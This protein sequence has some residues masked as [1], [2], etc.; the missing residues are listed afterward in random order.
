MEIFQLKS[1]ITEDVKCAIERI[2]K[3]LES[4]LQQISGKIWII[5]GVDIHSCTGIHD[6]DILLIG[7]LKGDNRYD[8]NGFQ[9]IK[10]R[11]FCTVIEIKN[12]DASGIIKEGTHLKVRYGAEEKDVTKQNESQKESLKRFL[13]NVLG[14]SKLKIPY[15]TN[16]I[17]LDGIEK[18]DFSRSIGLDESNIL[19]S[20][21]TFTDILNALGRRTSLRNN[22][23]IDAFKSYDDLK[24]ESFAEIFIAKVRGADTISLRRINHLNWKNNIE[25]KLLYH[26]KNVSILAGHAGTGKTLML[27]KSAVEKSKRGAKILFLTYNTALLSDLKHTVSLLPAMFLNIEMKSMHSYLISH[28]YRHNLWKNESKIEC[29]FTLALKVFH[30]KIK[31]NKI[32]ETKYDAVYIDEAQDW[33][34]PL[35]DIIKELFSD[36]KIIIA[37][38]IDQFMNKEDKG[39]WVKKSFPTLKQCKRQ[40][41]NL[42]IFVRAFASKLGVGWNVLPNKE[43][44]GGKVIVLHK[45]EPS[46]HFKLLKKIEKDD[47]KE[48][49]LML[50]ASNSM[51][52]NGKFSLLEEYEKRGIKLYDGTNKNIREEIYDDKCAE[53]K[54]SRIYSYESCRGLESWITVCLRYDEL[55]DKDHPHDYKDIQY[56]TAR[57]YMKALW[58]LIPL[59]RAID[60]LVLVVKKQCSLD[61]MLKELAQEYPDIVTYKQ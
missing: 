17:W 32:R 41:R 29:D 56:E 47:C 15:I 4:A 13:T 2:C 34:N 36:K 42:T 10:L 53:R 60:T 49:D 37:D 11:S 51:M 12:H 8:L 21:S 22:G 46:N 33:A 9:N 1:H 58:S 44:P 3:I 23:Y 45:Y 5:P 20:D 18:G 57:N 25:E 61:K 27:L 6:L 26:E 54:E 30:A 28:F 14:Y 16:F 52:W 39:E 7:Y 35:P 40:K 55:F 24:I 50:L 48:Y 38:G 59:T 19:C 43:L 31:K